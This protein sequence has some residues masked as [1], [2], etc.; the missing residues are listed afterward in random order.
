MQELVNYGRLVGLASQG[1][2]KSR[3]EVRRVEGNGKIKI[4]LNSLLQPHLQ[5]KPA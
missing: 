3:M 4:I 5:G 1:E 2:T